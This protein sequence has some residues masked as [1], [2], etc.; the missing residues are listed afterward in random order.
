VVTAGLCA[1][2]DK[3]GARLAVSRLILLFTT[4]HLMWADSG[5][6]RRPL[7]EW[8]NATADITLEIVK[9]TSPHAFQVMKRRWVVERTFG[10][11]MRYRRLARDYERR[12]EHHEAMVWW[13]TVFIMT[14]RLARYEAG[15]S[16]PPRWAGER[17]RPARQAATNRLLTTYLPRC[18]RPLSR[19]FPFAV[20]M[21]LVF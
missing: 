2:R 15:Q 16:Q 12:P 4:L 18:A 21:R 11:L 13:T 17:V 8:M 5:Y 6:D 14:K 10:W 19:P 7:R 20:P 9:R 1:A 3:A